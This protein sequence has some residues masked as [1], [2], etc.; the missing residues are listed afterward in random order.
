MSFILQGLVFALVAL[1]FLLIVAIPVI[2]A[3]SEGWEK[4]KGLILKSS[5]VWV[6]IVILTGILNSFG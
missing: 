5:G 1:S 6:S 4:S 3:S 2:S